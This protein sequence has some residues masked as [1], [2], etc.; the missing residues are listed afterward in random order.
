MLSFF[1]IILAAAVYGA[2]HSL[3]A[4]LYVKALAEK[5]L[6]LFIRRFY[7]LFFNLFSI[8]SFLVVFALVIWL[9]DQ[10]LYSVPSPWLWLMLILQVLAGLLGLVSLRQT[11]L[12]ALVGLEQVFSPEGNSRPR[13]LSQHGFYRWMRHPV[14]TFSLLFIWMTPRMS[15]NLLALYLGFTLYILVGI[16]FE[17]KKLLA[18]FGE[19]YAEYR[20]RT[21]MLIP[22]FF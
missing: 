14:Y 18:E 6:G 3:T 2:L 10:L 13:P 16:Y 9:P 8:A 4:S 15:L 11:G 19:T 20:R 22:P 21:P 1:W 7:R 12:S 5:R 17:E